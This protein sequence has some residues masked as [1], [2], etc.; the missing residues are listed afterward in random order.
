MGGS[1]N[2]GS[3]PTSPGAGQGGQ[4]SA[5]AGPSKSAGDPAGGSGGGKG[6]GCP[7]ELLATV[8]GPDRGLNPGMPLVVTLDR[9]SH[10]PRVVLTD[11]V[12]RQPVG[13][14]AGVPE[15]SILIDCLA[16]GVPYRAAVVAADGGRI[17]VRIVRQSE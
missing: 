6:G 2:S 16:A 11:P 10:V 4:A 1:S 9:T 15:L 12:S 8:H 3:R 17:D 5:G 7:S 13:A 14:I